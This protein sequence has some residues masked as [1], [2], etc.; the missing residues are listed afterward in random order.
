MRMRFSFSGSSF[1][2]PDFLD[3]VAMEPP[4]AAPPVPVAKSRLWG[5]YF[6]FL[7]TIV[8][9]GIIGMPFAIRQSGVVAGVR[10][11]GVSWQAHLCV[12]A[13]LSIERSSV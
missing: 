5:A 7:N 9:A 12:A 3:P 1:G 4:A 11:E 6:N 10:A 13:G 8:G 2:D